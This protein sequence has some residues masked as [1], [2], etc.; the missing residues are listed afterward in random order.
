MIQLMILILGGLAIL[1]MSRTDKWCKWG[2]AAG[3]LSEPLWIY[4]ALRTDQ[5]GVFILAAWW[6]L[7]YAVGLW[8]R[9]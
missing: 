1:L 9:L 3:L 2:F 6:T 5:W 4:E 7:W 8:R